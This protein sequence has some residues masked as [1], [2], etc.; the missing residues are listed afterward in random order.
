MIAQR[1]ITGKVREAARRD[2]VI[3]TK[4]VRRRMQQRKMTFRQIVHVLINGVEVETQPPKDPGQNPLTKLKGEAAGDVVTV[5]A[6]VRR[7]HGNE[8]AVVVTA[9]R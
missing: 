8:S 5:I 7:L 3:F 9:W 2:K 6:S 1:K 4:H